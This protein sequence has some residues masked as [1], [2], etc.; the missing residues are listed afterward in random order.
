MHTMDDADKDVDWVTVDLRRPTD[1]V[2]KLLEQTL[3]QRQ[4]DTIH[5]VVHLAGV[6]F[7]DR[8]ESTTTAEWGDTFAVNLNAARAVLKVAAPSLASGA[9]VVLVSSVDARMVAQRGLAAAYGASKAGL[10]GLARHL[11]VEWGNRGVRVNAVA[12]G[13]LASGTGPQN[14]AVAHA[15]AR[16][17][18]LG[19]LGRPEEVAEVI[20]FLLSERASYV[21]GA[22]VAVDGGLG[23][24]Y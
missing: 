10:E 23:L 2:V 21:S 22:V 5:G 18:A 17:A 24:P 16:R 13:A 4:I 19:R 3:Q 14:A 9:S 11:A 6:I 15:V 12:P 1:E 7:S 8:F 20:R